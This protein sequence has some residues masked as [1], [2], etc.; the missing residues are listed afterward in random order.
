MDPQTQMLAEIR[1]RIV[2]VET[3]LDSMHDVYDTALEA[4]NIGLEASQSVRSAHY[5]I[6]RIDRTIFWLSTT[7]IGAVILALVRL[8]LD[9]KV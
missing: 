4:K 3:K 2:R 9:G 1:E 7:V 6:D 5:R 8:V